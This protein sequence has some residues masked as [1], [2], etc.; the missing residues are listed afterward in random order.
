LILPRGAPELFDFGF[1][2]AAGARK[3]TCLHAVGDVA[4]AQVEACRLNLFLGD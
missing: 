4:K 2:F 3:K 1:D